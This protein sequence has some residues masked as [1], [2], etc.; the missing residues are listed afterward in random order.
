M[1]SQGK[2]TGS[3]CG[4]SC[5]P[6]PELNGLCAGRDKVAFIL[7][8]NGFTQDCCLQPP[9]THTLMVS[10]PGGLSGTAANSTPH[11]FVL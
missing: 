4:I 9:K 7:S 5:F 8:P 3:L 1:G 6:H 2:E 10:V 11:N